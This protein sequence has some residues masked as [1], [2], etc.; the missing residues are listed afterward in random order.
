MINSIL[1]VDVSCF[2]NCRGTIPRNVSL[3]S[4]LRNDQYHDRVQE[5]RSI[6][7]QNLQDI[8][9]KSLP[10]ITPSGLFKYRSEKDFV[11]HS[12]FLAFDIDFKD[13]QHIKNFSELREQ[14]S[15]IGSVSYCGLSVRGKGFWGLVPVPKSTPEIHKQRFASLKKDF[16]EFGINLDPSGSDVCRLRICSWDTDAYFNH[17]AKIYTK[18]V[19]PQK[20]VHTRPKDS[21]MRDK[22]EAIITQ[23]KERKID[24]TED[25]KNEWLKIAAAFASTFG[26]SG[27]GY[28]HTVSMFHPKY[29]I[30]DTDKLFDAC[31]KHNYDKV[32]IASFFK[33]AT[34]NGIKVEVHPVMATPVPLLKTKVL[35]Q[36]IDLK[37]PP[38]IKPDNKKGLWDQDIAD[39]EQFFKRIKSSSETIRLNHCSI[40]NDT[41]LFIESHLSI[42]KAQNGNTRYECYLDRLK[43]LRRLLSIN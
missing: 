14:I 2:E 19:H 8:I 33:I 20:R 23:I 10:V 39:L 30:L 25:Y 38:L 1:N 21:D 31:L 28:F 17:Q 11:E 6:Q 32:T 35:A 5:L 13:N 36:K 18:L 26:E 12:G 27:R 29:S 9:K 41:S 37:L 7:D 3:L 15:H 24:I 43:E 4:W 34:E 40:I 22:V 16:A 42:V